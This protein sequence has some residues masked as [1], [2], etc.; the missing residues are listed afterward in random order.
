MQVVSVSA[1]NSQASEQY[2]NKTYAKS[3]YA[4]D[5]EKIVNGLDVNSDLRKI[6]CKYSLASIHSNIAIYYI[7]TDGDY[8][9]I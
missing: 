9:F 7:N 8:G 2:L 4:P 3:A 6:G 5:Y 1:L